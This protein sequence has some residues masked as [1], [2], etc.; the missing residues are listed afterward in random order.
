MATDGFPLGMRPVAL[1]GVVV[2][3][4]GGIGSPCSR[5]QDSGD[6]IV[7]FEI[8]ARDSA[9]VDIGAQ[10][11][12]RDGKLLW[13]DGGKPVLV[14]DGAA[15]QTS[16]AACDDGQGGA[17][18]FYVH[19]F[20]GGEHAGDKDIVMQHLDRNGRR[21]WSEPKQ[22]AGSKSVETRPLPVS[23]GQGGAVVVYLW[24]GETGDSDLLAQRIGPDGRLLWNDGK[25]PLTVGASK[26][27]ERNACVVP[28]GQGGVFVFFEWVGENGD[29]DISGQHVT[30]DGQFPWKTAQRALDIA[31]SVQKESHPVAVSDG[32]GGAIVA[33]EVE[34]TSG[35]NRG[36]IDIMAQRVSSGGTLLWG[37]A[38]TPKVV[39]A[40]TALERNPAAIAD[41]AG[42]IMVAFEM[43]PV[44]GENKGDSDVLAQ[45]LN[46]DGQPQ[47]EQGQ[48]SVP[49]SSSTDLERW[50]A[51]V[52]DGAGG[53][54][55]AV[56]LEFRA[57][58]NQR[59]KDI[60]AQ[61]ISP[62][63]K[64]M[65]ND[66][67]KSAAVGTAKPWLEERPIALTDSHGGAIIVYPA[68]AR[69]GPAD[70]DQDL[71]AVRVDASGKILWNNGERAVDV[72]A[73]KLLERNPSAFVVGAAKME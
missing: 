68:T 42:G 19:E 62:L 45:R 53:F 72:A 73:T 20:V 6:V 29:I 55:A 36:D 54:I 60:V 14:A 21:L 34:F 26:N 16:P 23:D 46:A 24:T 56:E 35:E 22:V 58:I 10:R 25:T 4:F 51:L 5:A 7:A 57:G 69:G 31:A 43:E 64:M 65:W 1:L 13:G 66:G 70:G 28:D 59:D 48:R 8:A 61:C 44:S 2:L 11:V 12:S 27:L 67:K 3:G 50:P 17:F 9:N 39:G 18:V 15:L 37:N 63:G 52:S 38:A 40:A 71:E 41:G 30:T 33:F 47:W 49:V 32:A